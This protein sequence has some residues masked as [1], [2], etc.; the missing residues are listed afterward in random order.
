MWKSKSKVLKIGLVHLDLISLT[1]SRSLFIFL[2]CCLP[3]NAVFSFHYALEAWKHSDL[4]RKTLTFKQNK[5]KMETPLL[6]L[7]FC[8]WRR[9]RLKGGSRRFES[10][11]KIRIVIKNWNTFKTESSGCIVCVW[12][13]QGGCFLLCRAL[14]EFMVR[15][16]ADHYEII[17]VHN[18]HR[19]TGSGRG[20][21]ASTLRD[22]LHAFFHPDAP[23]G[24]RAS[25]RGLFS[26]WQDV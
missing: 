14:I 9:W 3:L 6:F 8:F 23:P 16:Q 12:Q 10:S 25:N 15:H 13:R 22:S 21:K 19:T 5:T 20:R 17:T 4:V 24:S 2:W 11:K 1:Y 26:L 7:L 18:G